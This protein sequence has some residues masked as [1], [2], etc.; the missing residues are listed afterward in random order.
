ML[1]DLL[2][3]DGCQ[4]KLD[5]VVV[6]K[7]VVTLMVHSLQTTALC[8]DC[9]QPSGRVHSTYWRTLADLACSERRVKVRLLVPRFFCGH[10]G[11]T[12]KTFAQRFPAL[13]IPF[14][15]RTNR[16][17]TRQ[18]QAGLEH[19]GE[20]A[21]RTLTNLAMPVS[22]DTVLRLVWSAPAPAIP[23]PRVLGIDDWAWC[24]GQRYGTLLVDLERHRPVD[25]LA[26]LDS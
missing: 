2:L 6:E 13:V 18:R 21:V 24:K 20:A 11:C 25:L 4:L 23:A 9:A 22:G 26:D 1:A 10:S 16:L 19:G 8:P 5:E 12:R 7:D 17:A 15:R 14:A 3:P